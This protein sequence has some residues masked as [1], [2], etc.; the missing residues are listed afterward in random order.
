MV[1]ESAHFSQ[2]DAAAGPGTASTSNQ[3]P[4]EVLITILTRQLESKWVSQ[5]APKGLRKTL[6]ETRACEETAT[7]R[8]FLDHGGMAAWVAYFRATYGNHIAG[9]RVPEKI[10]AAFQRVSVQD[11][12]EAARRVA[13]A[14][15]HHTVTKIIS[16][17]PQK[18]QRK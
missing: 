11:R 12:I 17:A 18:R 8:I 10:L 2:G 15:Q 3:S 9:Q 7:E 4:I 6:V 1:M 5:R 14:S 16:N 13:D